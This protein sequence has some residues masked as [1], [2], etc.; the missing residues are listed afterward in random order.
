MAKSKQTRKK[1]TEPTVSLEARLATAI[2]QKSSSERN[3]ERSSG[4]PNIGDQVR[5]DG[6]ETIYLVTAISPDDREV[7]LNLPGTN[8]E[9]Y[10]VS[11]DDLDY[12][13][14][15]ARAQSGKS[16][17]PKPTW[18]V[19]QVRKEIEKAKVSTEESLE[20]ELSILNKYLKDKGVPSVVADELEKMSQ[21]VQSGWDEVLEGLADLLEPE[22]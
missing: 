22:S 4:L 1:Q 19:E 8:L 10:R 11:V 5:I 12:V 14:R 18:T 17:P 20:R 13:Q 3:H 2:S 6:S 21:D 7:N 16:R 15:V 9:R